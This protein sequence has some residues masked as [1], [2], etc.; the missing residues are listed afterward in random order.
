MIDNDLRVE[1]QD[2]LGKTLGVDCIPDDGPVADRVPLAL[3]QRYRLEIVRFFEQPCLLMIDK[4]IT[5]ITLT[6]LSVHQ[7]ILSGKV[8][9]PLVY[10]AKRITPDLRR[11][12]VAARMAFVVPGSQA[13]LPFLG[14]AL[15]ERFQ[16]IPATGAPLRPASQV[17]LL[18]WVHHGF[19]GAETATR[20]VQHLGYTKVSLSR[21]FEDLSHLVSQIPGLT[22]SRVGRERQ[23]VWRGNA[24]VLWQAIQGVLR[25]PVEGRETVAIPLQ[26]RTQLRLAGLSALAKCSDLADPP[27]PVMAMERLAW[28]SYRRE[29]G[30]LAATADDPLAV[31]VETWSYTPGFHDL[32]AV[33]TQGV[34][35][36]LSVHRSLVRSPH[37][38]DERVEAALEH[39]IKEFPWRW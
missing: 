18:W 16:K 39:L 13:Y 12:L 21:V 22:I 35:D 7:G 27:I 33:K 38:Q 23:A 10:V 6:Q 34:A 8:D 19:D 1:M 4:E 9:E 5:G 26:H 3:S 14:M 2:Y 30:I 24:K 37:A 25:D 28:K 20:L 32:H 17:A 11:R 36:L 15:Q 29:H 31:E